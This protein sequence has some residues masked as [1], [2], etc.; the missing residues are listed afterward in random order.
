LNPAENAQNMLKHTAIPDLLKRDSVEWIGGWKNK[1][2]I[3]EQ[4]IDLLTDGITNA[5]YLRISFVVTASLEIP[6]SHVAVCYN[7]EVI[8]RVPSLI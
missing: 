4:A 8:S 7:S 3:V 2:A 6:P 5:N 1:V